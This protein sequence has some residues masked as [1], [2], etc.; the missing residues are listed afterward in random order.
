MIQ[1]ILDLGFEN[2]ELSHG[3]RVSLIGGIQQ[4]YDAGKVRISSL[5]NFCPLPLEILWAR[6]RIVTSSPATGR[7]TSDA[8]SSSRSRPSTSR[9]ASARPSSCCTSAAWAW[10]RVTRQLASKWLRHGQKGSRE[11]VKLKIEAIREREKKGPGY[12]ERVKT[13]LAPIVEHAAKRNI[14]LG[15]EEPL[16]L[17]GSPQR[18]RTAHAARRTR[19]AA[20]RL[21][22]RFRAHPGQAQ[23][24]VSGSLRMAQ[25]DPPPAFRLP[26]AR[27]PM[28][29][30]GS[31]GAV[32]GRD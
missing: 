22:A 27:H 30:H 18:A 4:M 12:L 15:I 17:R 14:L 26:P 7:S 20:R 9:N 8:R 11:F 29:Q 28:A 21:L 5:H 16:R 23:P 1:E 32:R 24:R 13:C 19:R 6:R 2:V 31:P 25:V 3:V 10:T